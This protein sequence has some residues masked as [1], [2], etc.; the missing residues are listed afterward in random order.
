LKIGHL[1]HYVELVDMV[2]LIFT[3]TFMF[4]KASGTLSNLISM[5]CHFMYV[6]EIILL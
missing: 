3:F 6:Y 1:Y 4:S 2:V 5:T